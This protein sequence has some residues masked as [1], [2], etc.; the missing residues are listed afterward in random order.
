MQLYE[1]QKTF[2]ELFFLVFLKSIFNF[3][4]FPKKDDPHKLM[5]FRKYRLPKTW[6]DKCLK[7][8]VSEDP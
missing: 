7:S 1:K 6:L 8:P 4:N 2:S 5:Y 3:K